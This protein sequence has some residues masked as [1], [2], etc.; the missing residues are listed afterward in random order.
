METSKIEQVIRRYREGT[1]TPE[2]NAWLESWYLAEGKRLPKMTDPIDYSAKGQKIWGRIQKKLP[3]ENRS[4]QP[5]KLI[6]VAAAILM[7]LGLAVY[8]FNPKALFFAPRDSRATE[9]QPGGNKAYLTLASGQRISLTDTV[10]GVLAQEV[11]VRITKTAEGQLIYEVQ[12]AVNTGENE[13]FNTIE[14]PNGGQFQVRLPDGTSVWLNA[15]STL[16]YP[17]SFSSKKERFVTLSGEAYFEVAKD[18][19]RPFIVSSGSQKV[20]VLGTHFNV[21]AYSDDSVIRTTLLEGK[22][23]VQ[24]TGP[25]PE[26]ILLKPHEQLVNNQGKLNVFPV[27]PLHV[28]EW[29]NGFFRF[30]GKD[31]EHSLKEIARWYNVEINYSNQALKAEPLAGRISKYSSIREVLTKME[32]TGAFHFTVDG[33]KILVE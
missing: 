17:V 1:T 15:S 28:I 32:L 7:L 33:R 12:S 16:T 13:G 18:Q 19:T 10:H 11:G 30:D 22:V 27:E 21:S 29:K 24:T 20:E 31:L 4:M 2:E 3:S 25:V 23:R 26:S 5:W 9:I 6:G 14:T 8:Y